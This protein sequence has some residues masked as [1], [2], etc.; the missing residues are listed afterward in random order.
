MEGVE[1]IDAKAKCLWFQETH[2]EGHQIKRKA[3]CLLLQRSLWSTCYLPMMHCS[4]SNEL[5]PAPTSNG[6]MISLENVSHKVLLENIK[7]F[8]IE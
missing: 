4:C 6:K 7:L 3:S 5:P 1:L 2:S 8:V